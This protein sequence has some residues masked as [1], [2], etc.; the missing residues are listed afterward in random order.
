MA[1]WR[2]WDGSSFPW[3]PCLP[4][5]RSSLTL[6]RWVPAVEKQFALKPTCSPNACRP[7]TL[8]S[9]SVADVL[10]KPLRRDLAADASLER[11]AVHD[12]PNRGELQP[13]VAYI[14]VERDLFLPGPPLH[15]PGHEGRDVGL[16][17]TAA[18]IP[19]LRI[20]STE[21]RVGVL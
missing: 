3:R 6:P 19:E 16:V 12:L 7:P 11:V 14:S 15:L 21:P 8:F 2:A 1:S 9:L 20:I 10:Q 17:P 13:L 18:A 5:K 4:Q